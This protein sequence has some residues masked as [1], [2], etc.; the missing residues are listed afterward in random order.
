MATPPTL[1]G[2]VSST[3]ASTATPKT[4]PSLSGISAGD[5]LVQMAGDESDDS[6]ENYAYTSSPSETWTEQ[7]ESNGTTGADGWLQT[8]TAIA[9]STSSYTGT[10][11]RSGGDPTQLFGDV[12]VAAG[13]SDG[14]G[15]TDRNVLAATATPSISFTT[16]ADNSAIVLIM[17][18]WN[19]ADGASRVYRGIGSGTT[20]VAGGGQEFY[21]RDSLHYTVYMAYWDDAGA[22]G[23]KTLGIS[24]GIAAS[25]KIVWA[26]V[27]IKGV[28][29]PPP[30]PDEG[31]YNNDATADMWAFAGYGMGD[32]SF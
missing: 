18:D 31:A 11:T 5:V 29:A 7:T 13:P 14:L 2:K 4:T 30:P 23:A 6:G 27:E 3:F 1:R 19:A 16:A 22:A 9:G 17:V 26:A 32:G 15:N 10:C 20:P 24:S 8:A 21:F 12:M 25:A 28:A